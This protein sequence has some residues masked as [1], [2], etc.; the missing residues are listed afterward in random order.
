M[1]GQ[2]TPVHVSQDAALQGGGR[3]GKTSGCMKAGCRR[4]GFEGRSGRSHNPAADVVDYR[5]CPRLGRLAAL[6]SR[7]SCW[8]GQVIPQLASQPEGVRGLSRWRRRPTRGA[9]ARGR[10]TMTP[11]THSNGATTTLFLSGEFDHSNART[12]VAGPWTPPSKTGSIRSS[13]TCPLSFSWVPGLS[14]L[15]FVRAADPWPAVPH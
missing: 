11:L 8:P 2:A 12:V 9:S 6:H 3:L 15:W 13:S 5:G 1:I 7:H 14:G 4:H 10:A